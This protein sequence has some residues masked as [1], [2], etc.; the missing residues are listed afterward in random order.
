[1]AVKKTVHGSLRMHPFR[2]SEAEQYCILLQNLA[3]LLLKME[4]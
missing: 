1:M 2:H 3:P 4:R